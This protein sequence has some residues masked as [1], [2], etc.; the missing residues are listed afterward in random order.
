MD[1]RQ[2]KVGLSC[3]NDREGFQCLVCL[4]VR[5]GIPNSSKGEKLV[6]LQVDVIWKGLIVDML[7]FVK[8]IG[9]DKAS[10][11]L[12]GMTEG[13]SS[14]DR[15]SLSIKRLL[16]DL[17]GSFFILYPERDQ[18]PGKELNLRRIVIGN[19]RK[20]WVRECGNMKDSLKD[21]VEKRGIEPFF[22]C[23]KVFARGDVEAHRGE[24][25]NRR[26]SWYPYSYLQEM[27]MKF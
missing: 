15:F 12:N 7:P 17:K 22:D 16:P 21:G 25:Q 6:I 5:P 13:R 3:C 2:E 8:T 20:S 18:P 19:D 14:G 23:S 11:Y 26:R 4:L 1:Y 10:F 9:K 24:F 27:S